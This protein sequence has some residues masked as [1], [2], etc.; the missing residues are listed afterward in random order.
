MIFVEP[1]QDIRAPHGP[2][3]DITASQDLL[4]ADGDSSNG[5]NKSTSKCRESKRIFSINIDDLLHSQ[6]LESNAM[7]IP[8][9]RKVS[10]FP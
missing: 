1:C 2:G 4:R 7:P 6:N 3:F 10:S 5:S 9:N 8:N